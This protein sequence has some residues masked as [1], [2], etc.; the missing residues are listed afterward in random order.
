M[1]LSTTETP[2]WRKRLGWRKRLVL[3]GVSLLAMLAATLTQPDAQ[4]QTPPSASDMQA[5]FAQL[6]TQAEQGNPEAQFR[7][8][9]L[10]QRGVGVE[11][12][13]VEA[14]RW[15][16]EA[17]QH[18]HAAAMNALGMMLW[19][20]FAGHPP[21][22]VEAVRWWQAAAQRGN[23]AA[24][25]NLG[26]AY[27]IGAGLAQDL[28]QA[29][30]WISLAAAKVPPGDKI[31]GERDALAAKLT[32][33]QMAQ[34][35]QSI[36]QFQPSDTPLPTGTAPVTPQTGT[37]SFGTGFF[38]R[39]DGMILTNAHVVR[40]CK[41]I[42]IAT[43]TTKGTANLTARDET[44]DLALLQTTLA[45]PAVAALR[46]DPQIRPGDAVVALG[47]PLKGM[48]SSQPVVTT[49]VVNA[50]AGLKDDARYMQIS[51][52]LQQ[53]NSGG[54]VVD[55][56]GHVIGVASAKLNALAVAALSGD[57]PQNVN[58]AVRTFVARQF[59]MDHGVTPAFAPTETELR[60]ADAAEIARPFVVSI[61]CR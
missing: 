2:C 51:A 12:K 10:Y 27:R 29:Y 35:R 15:Y 46:S 57:M 56:G 13:P 49:G 31:F 53:G 30:V 47:Y 22:P 48:L 34:A 41:D 11:A 55:L 9:L 14:A 26:S 16:R 28:T 43:L 38:V 45:A 24:Q 4:A 20:G 32:P 8:A 7:L 5:A 50:L 36:A 18:N 1:P 33:E 37:P 42:T 39:G 25:Y 40:T 60:P 54:P 58:F 17:A 3:T 61:E 21:L 44:N 19:N 23:V 52:P 59:L 6:K